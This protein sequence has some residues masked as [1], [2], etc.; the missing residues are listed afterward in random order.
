MPPHDHLFKPLFQAGDTAVRGRGSGLRD[1]RKGRRASLRRT[2]VR[3]LR[4]RFGRYP[5][6]Q[7]A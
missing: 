1:R 6:L 3:L 4:Q 7:S 2:L 5:P